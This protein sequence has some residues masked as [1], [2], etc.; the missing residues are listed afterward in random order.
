MTIAVFN[1]VL[2][3][4]L[5]KLTDRD[6]DQELGGLLP[7]AVRAGLSVQI[8]VALTGALQSLAR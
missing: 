7:A 6:V 8:R 2:S 4:A 5:A 1:N 3:Q